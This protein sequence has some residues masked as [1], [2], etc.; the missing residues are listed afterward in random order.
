V[1]RLISRFEV[2]AVQKDKLPVERGGLAGG[3]GG[4]TDGQAKVYLD[5][6]VKM[7]PAEVI[8]LYTFAIKLVP[9]I[10]QKGSSEVGAAATNA[11]NA[12]SPLQFVVAWALFALGIILTPIALSVEDP[13][14]LDAKWVRAW[15]VRLGLATVA[16]PLWAYATSGEY[17]PGVTYNNALS[18]IVVAVYAV[19]AGIVAKKVA[20]K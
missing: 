6:I 12:S 8:T 9:L 2:P 11:A 1:S 17:L 3:E 15:T 20:P 19:I 7:I 10:T 18:L 4:R 5:L 16:F 13:K 14:P